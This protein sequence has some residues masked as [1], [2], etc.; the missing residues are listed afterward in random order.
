MPAAERPY[1]LIPNYQVHTNRVFEI[2]L[3]MLG[4]KTLILL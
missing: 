1:V 3:I 2:Y 4:W